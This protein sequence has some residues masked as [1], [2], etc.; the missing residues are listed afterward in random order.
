MPRQIHVT[1]SEELR[2]RLWAI[3]KNRPEPTRWQDIARAAM[4]IGLESL[5]AQKAKTTQV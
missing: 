2:D 4:E 5:V 1:I 3:A